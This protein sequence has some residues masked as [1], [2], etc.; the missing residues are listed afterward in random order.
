MITKSSPALPRK[1]PP[2]WVAISASTGPSV[3][4]DILCWDARRDTWLLDSQQSLSV[5]RWA[6]RV[7]RCGALGTA[8]GFGEVCAGPA[9]A[10]RCAA[11]TAKHIRL[12]LDEHEEAKNDDDDD[13][14]DD[15]DS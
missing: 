4:L 11:D 6:V 5:G 2:L 7:R 8:R 10:V 14:D 3:A 1:P 15:G 13:D 9:F 12:H